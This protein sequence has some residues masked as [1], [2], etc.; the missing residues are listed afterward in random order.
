MKNVDLLKQYLMM[1]SPSDPV[2]LAQASPERLALTL[3]T[4]RLT[5]SDAA[6]LGVFLRIGQAQL[7]C[8]WRFVSEGAAHVVVV[9]GPEPDTVPGL[10]DNP[11]ATLHVLDAANDPAG[12]AWTS[13][14]RPLQYEAFTSALSPTS[15]FVFVASHSCAASASS[16]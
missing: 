15:A 13:L 16:L 2:A 4:Q 8:D 5:E 9:A 1:L 14:L 6:K 3:L 11:R 10:L 7:L 12:D